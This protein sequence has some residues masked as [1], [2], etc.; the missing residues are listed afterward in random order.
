MEINPVHLANFTKLPS[1]EMGLTSSMGRALRAMTPHK[2]EV[3][4]EYH[5]QGLFR[6][7]TNDM[8]AMLKK[9]RDLEDEARDFLLAR[10]LGEYRRPQLSPT[11]KDDKQS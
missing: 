1:V 10:W 2:G 3:V 6:E 11:I 8:G 4:I 9:L 5:G 7:K